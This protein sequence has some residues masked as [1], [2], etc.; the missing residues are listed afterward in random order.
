MEK[1]Y[2][3][4]VLNIAATGAP[5]GRTGCF[6]GRDALTIRLV[7]PGRVETKWE[8]LRKGDYFCIDFW[9]WEYGVTNAPL[10]RQHGW[11]RSVSWLPGLYTLEN[12]NCGGNVKSLEHVRLSRVGYQRSG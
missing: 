1:V 9:L 3:E 2:K 4:S 6:S 7:E 5:D 11:S 12:H 8:G 10:N